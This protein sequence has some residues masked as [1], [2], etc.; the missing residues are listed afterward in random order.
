MLKKFISAIVAASLC[1]LCLSACQ[2]SQQK[3]DI[4]ES[5]IGWDIDECYKDL[6]LTPGKDVILY[7]G[8]P[9]LMSFVPKPVTYFD[10]TFYKAFKYVPEMDGQFASRTIEKIIYVMDFYESAGDSVA[11]KA[12]ELF[13]KTQEVYGKPYMYTI[14]RSK[15]GYDG[16]PPTISRSPETAY[17]LE[18]DKISEQMA[19]SDKLGD[20]SVGCEWLLSEATDKIEQTFNQGAED[21]HGVKFDYAVHANLQYHAGHYIFTITHTFDSLERRGMEG[22]S[23]TLS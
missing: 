19:K 17:I 16:A 21:L 1:V 14:G 9:M 8:G 3:P 15:E 20:L 5:Y 6:G 11:E 18:K 23:D 12:A 2:P 13:V 4:Y 10:E 22:S 7:Y